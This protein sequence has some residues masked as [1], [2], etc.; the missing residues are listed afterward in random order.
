MVEFHHFFIRF[1]WTTRT[2]SKEDATLGKYVKTYVLPRFFHVFDIVALARKLG[3]CVENPYQNAYQASLAIDFFRKGLFPCY[4]HSKWLP[5]LHQ[6]A[7][8]DAAGHS[9]GALGA[10][11]GALGRSWGALGAL[12]GR[13]CT[14]L[15]RS[16]SHHD[17]S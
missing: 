14:L 17:R 9:W 10:C 16:W 3:E 1:P 11:W 2:F 8:G 6:D 4:G 5:R 13:S 15:G 12:L 7:T